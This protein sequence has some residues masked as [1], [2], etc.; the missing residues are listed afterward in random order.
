MAEDLHSTKILRKDTLAKFQNYGLAVDDML[1]DVE[2]MINEDSRTFF[3]FFQ[4]MKHLSL[5]A[6]VYVEQDNKSGESL[7]VDN[8]LLRM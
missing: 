4:V 3:K 8:L 5:L 7:Y 6:R 2:A 1:T